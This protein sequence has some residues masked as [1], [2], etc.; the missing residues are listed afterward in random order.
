MLESNL[1]R[2]FRCKK[3]NLKP[4]LSGL[5]LFSLLVGLG[6]A[7]YTNNYSNTSS[8]TLELNKGFY[9][10]IGLEGAEEYTESL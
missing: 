5:A 4:I 2:V 9:L 10:G 7:A 8:G 1:R 3:Q 6:G